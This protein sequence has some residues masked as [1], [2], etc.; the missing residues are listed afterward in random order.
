MLAVDLERLLGVKAC[1]QPLALPL[2]DERRL[3]HRVRAGALAAGFGG[4]LERRL[5]VAGR[6]VPVAAKLV[7]ARAPVAD[8]GGEKRRRTGRAGI[9]LERA[10][11]ER[12]RLC[13]LRPL[14]GDAACAV[15]DSGAVG[16]VEVGRL[17]DRVGLR[18][19]IGCDVEPALVHLR[20]RCRQAMPEG[21]RGIL[22]NVG[23]QR[24]ELLERG[25]VVV[26]ARERLRVAQPPL[27]VAAGE[28]REHR[29]R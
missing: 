3:E 6:G 21:E 15:E 22:L 13:D 10:R 8:V 4:E 28:D 9:R 5:G 17:H 7:A 24:V 27:D 18:E 2:G 26:V 11:E 19:Q 14:E 29:R 23:P 25:D 16:R 20:P 12:D 1:E